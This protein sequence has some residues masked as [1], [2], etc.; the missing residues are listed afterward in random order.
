MYFINSKPSYDHLLNFIPVLIPDFNNP[1]PLT[2]TGMKNFWNGNWNEKII[3]NFRERESEAGIPRNG[4]EREFPLTPVPK[5]EFA[6]CA[7]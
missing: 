7:K 3:P 1:F 4:R 2:G 5:R 6:R